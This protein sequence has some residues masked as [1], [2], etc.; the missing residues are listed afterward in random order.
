MVARFGGRPNEDDVDGVTP[1]PSSFRH[2]LILYGFFNVA[3]GLRVGVRLGT[4][5]A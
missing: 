5:V 3:V 4:G 2:L 1:T